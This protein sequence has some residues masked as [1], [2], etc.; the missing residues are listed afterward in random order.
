M[1]RGGRYI[2]VCP[3]ANNVASDLYCLSTQDSCTLVRENA[4][5]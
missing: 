2:H 5:M 3:S 4:R 1:V